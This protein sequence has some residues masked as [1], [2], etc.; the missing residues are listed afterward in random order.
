[1]SVTSQNCDLYI[2]YRINLV[3]TSCTVQY[4]Y[5]EDLVSVYDNS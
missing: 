1:M 5:D 4:I 3:K 2:T